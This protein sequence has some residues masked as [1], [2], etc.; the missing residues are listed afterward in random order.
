MN[1]INLIDSNS[2]FILE[3]IQ[4]IIKT[5]LSEVFDVDQKNKVDFK[6]TI[7]KRIIA[8]VKEMVIDLNIENFRFDIE[9]IILENGDDKLLKMSIK[10]THPYAEKIFKE[11]NFHIL[12]RRIK[13]NK[14]FE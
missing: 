10:P 3:N 8:L 14:I 9:V 2:K 6:I 1:D 13:I 5:E 4:D 12:Y 7:K 11:N